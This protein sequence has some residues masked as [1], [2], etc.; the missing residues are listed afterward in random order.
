ML[1]NLEHHER[2][3]ICTADNRRM[4]VKCTK[5]FNGT[6]ILELLPRL[7]YQLRVQPI[8]AQEFSTTSLFFSYGILLLPKESEDGLIRTVIAMNM[9]DKLVRVYTNME[10][11]QERTGGCSPGNSQGS[12][13]GESPERQKYTSNDCMYPF[14]V[15]SPARQERSDDNIILTEEY[16]PEQGL[17]SSSVL[18]SIQLSP[19]TETSHYPS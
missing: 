4:Y 3:E 8:S 14:R 19:R 7:R 15:D 2:V 5:S 1:L 13:P 18:A 10:M 6:P 11:N 12:S 17:S 16:S 9:G